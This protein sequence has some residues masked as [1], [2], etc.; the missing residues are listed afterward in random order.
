MEYALQQLVTQFESGRLGRRKLVLALLGLVAGGHAAA[1]KQE[2]QST[3]QAVG[4]NHIALSVTNIARSRDFYVRH[5]DLQVTRQSSSSC[6]LKCGDNFVALF[7]QPEAGLNH[8]CYAIKDFDLSDCARLLKANEI[9]PRIAGNRVYF[10]DPDG[11]EVQLAA[12]DHR[13]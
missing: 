11:I 3:F 1:A 7:G 10:D 13:A 8:Y 6:F 12:R 2:S 9:Q 5:L 4:L